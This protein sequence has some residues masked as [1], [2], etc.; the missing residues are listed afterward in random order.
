MKT[1]GKISAALVGAATIALLLTGCHPD[2]ND[3]GG[4]QNLDPVGRVPGSSASPTDPSQRNTSACEI[5]SSATV[6]AIDAAV[7]SH[8]NTDVANVRKG[9]GGWYVGASIAPSNDDPNDDEVTVW[10][11]T[12]DPTA[13]GFDGTL[14]PVNEAAKDAV[15]DEGNGASTAPSSFD[16]SSE[17]A[18]QVVSCVVQTVNH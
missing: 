2:A 14:Y 10:A 17:T 9:G 11:T 8:D 6:D 16:A 18:K 13:D 4:A 12:T 7:G 1:R 3:I 15:A 5:A